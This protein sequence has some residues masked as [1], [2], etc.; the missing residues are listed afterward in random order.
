MTCTIEEFRNKLR[1]LEEDC[2]RS[3]T[4]FAENEAEINALF[5]MVESQGV[6]W[7]TS[8]LVKLKDDIY[9]LL[10]EE[11]EERPGGVFQMNFYLGYNKY[12]HYGIYCTWGYKVDNA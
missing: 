12:K 10:F 6:K 8:D 3:F 9:Q 11:K 1:L 4:L 5:E 2:Y 7:Y